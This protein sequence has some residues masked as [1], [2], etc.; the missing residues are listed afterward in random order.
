MDHPSWFYSEDS[1]YMADDIKS[2]I[3][4]VEDLE[5]DLKAA[6]YDLGR[7]VNTD[8]VKMELKGQQITGLQK[9]GVEM[10]KSIADLE[11]RVKTLESK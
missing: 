1:I 7:K 8:E 6:K 4:R 11:K 3:K 10:A 5:K 2:L 9:D